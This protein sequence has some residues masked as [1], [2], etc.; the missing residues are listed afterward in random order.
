MKI[1]ISRYNNPD[2]TF[3]EY[4]IIKLKYIKNAETISK[5]NLI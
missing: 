2:L 3:N 5:N 4:L 1:L